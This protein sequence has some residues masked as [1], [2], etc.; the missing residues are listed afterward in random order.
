MTEGIF[1]RVAGWLNELV[2]VYR[3]LL[4][5][6]GE[7]RNALIAGDISRIEAITADETRLA[8]QLSRLEEEWQAWGSRPAGAQSGSEPALSSL[9]AQAAA[10]DASKLTALQTELLGLLGQIA[11]FNRINEGLIH[12]SLRWVGYTQRLLQPEESLTYNAAGAAGGTDTSAA[13]HYDRQA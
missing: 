12:H 11:D 6:E 7:K 13:R 3:E 4:N 10:A 9:I 5:R 2:P 8:E 1:S